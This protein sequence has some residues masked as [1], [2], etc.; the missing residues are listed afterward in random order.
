M[1]T[2]NIAAVIVKVRIFPLNYM[3][4]EV[5]I[6]ISSIGNAQDLSG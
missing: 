4:Q 2:K 3:G 1:N 6:T 5:D